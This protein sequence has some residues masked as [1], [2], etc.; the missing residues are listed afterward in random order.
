M[1][2]LTKPPFC[3]GARRGAFIQSGVVA[4]RSA[5]PTTC[6]SSIALLDAGVVLHDSLFFPGPVFVAGG[7]TFI[8]L[9][10][11]PTQTEVEFDPAIAVMQVQRHE[12]VSTLFGLP[13]EL[14]DLFRMK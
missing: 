3:F 13:D 14:F 11:A 2:A 5:W 9:L 6:C 4:G 10:L 8:V 1:A 7:V 12:R